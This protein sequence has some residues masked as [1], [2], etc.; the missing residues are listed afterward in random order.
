MFADED[1]ILATLSQG[2]FVYFVVS[3]YKIKQIFFFKLNIGC[4]LEQRV[5]SMSSLCKKVVWSNDPAIS[6]LTAS[7]RY[8]AIF[9]DAA[10]VVAWWWGRFGNLNLQ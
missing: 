1:S 7:L 4:V 2:N 6:F 8:K 10:V 9:D 3:Q 5:V